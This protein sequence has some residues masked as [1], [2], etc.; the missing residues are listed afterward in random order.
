MAIYTIKVVNENR[1]R[2]NYRAFM[3]PRLDVDWNL[4]SPWA[5][6]DD[7][8]EGGAESVEYAP[9]E[10][11]GASAPSFIIADGDF[12]PGEISDQAS[13]A[14]VATIDF[15]GRSETKATATQDASGAFTVTYD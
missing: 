3:R 8:P 4:P 15:A 1:Q 11:A 7:V 10:V 14:H 9:P 12:T 13:P 2:Q 6:L 5:T